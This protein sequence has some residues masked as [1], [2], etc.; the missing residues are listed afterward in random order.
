M[1]EALTA[2]RKTNVVMRKTIEEETLAL[3]KLT[4]EIHILR[5]VV[6]IFQL[7]LPNKIFMVFKILFLFFFY[8]SITVLNVFIYL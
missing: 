5:T 8:F 3:Q 2:N 7:G 1:W 4:A 6:L